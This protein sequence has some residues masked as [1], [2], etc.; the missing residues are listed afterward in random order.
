LKHRNSKAGFTL[1]EVMVTLI[2]VGI[3]LTLILQ[4]LNAA[5][6]TA[7]HTHNRKVARELAIYTLG[8]MEAG[9]FWEE[10]E[11]GDDQLSGTYAEQGYEYFSWII[12]VGD[13]NFPEYEDSESGYHDTYAYRR[14][15]EEEDEDDDLDE[16]EDQSEPYERISIRVTFPKLSDLPN[17]LEFERWIPWDQV[18]GVDEDAVEEEEPAG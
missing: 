13:E 4:G 14:Y 11:Y 17:E 12:V 7:A 2:V 8:E 1:A 5:K 15:Q 18:Y 16:D 3:T 6:M 9:L 10:L